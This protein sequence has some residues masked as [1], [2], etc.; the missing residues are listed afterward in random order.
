MIKLLVLLFLVVWPGPID[1]PRPITDYPAVMVVYDPSLPER[2]PDDPDLA[3]NCDGDCST[4]ASGDL[5]D[6]M[7]ESAGACDASL[8][9][10]T[11]YFPAIDLEIHCVDRGGDIRPMWSDH[12]GQMVLYFDVLWHLDKVDRRITGA[13]EWNYWLL[14]DWVVLGD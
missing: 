4:V 9:G 12:H 6:W 2:Y 10:R 8:F 3:I 14:E 1:E 13:P 11:V 7:Y 5:E